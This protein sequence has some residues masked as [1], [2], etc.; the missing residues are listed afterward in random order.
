MT[1]FL[2]KI[3]LGKSFDTMNEDQLE[4]ILFRLAREKDTSVLVPLI[5]GG[6]V[7]KGL[8]SVSLTLVL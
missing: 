2:V 7:V 1:L 3:L 5:F 8:R 4:R 6:G